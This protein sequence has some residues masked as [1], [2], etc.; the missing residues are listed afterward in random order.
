MAHDRKVE[1]LRQAQFAAREAAQLR[2]ETQKVRTKG[3][4][5]VARPAHRPVV[6]P[7]RSSQGGRKF[8]AEVEAH[9][10]SQLRTFEK[11][12]SAQDAAKATAKCPAPACTKSNRCRGQWLVNSGKA[13]AVQ[14]K[15][16]DEGFYKFATSFEFCAS[17]ETSIS[18]RVQHHERPRPFH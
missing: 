8:K 1:V 17:A 2:L 11:R 14:L 12:L 6:P 15:F 9:V 4:H 3:Q 7:A 13:G 18:I 16:E 10:E 5:A